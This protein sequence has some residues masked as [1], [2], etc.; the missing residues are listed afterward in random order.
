MIRAA[1]GVALGVAMSVTAF[2]VLVRI[3]TDRGIQR[4]GV[5]ALAISCAGVDDVAAWCHAQGEASVAIGQDNRRSLRRF[6][7]GDSS[8]GDGS[9][10]SSATTRP[11]IVM[12]WAAGD[13]DA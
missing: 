8:I 12:A 13:G 6:C 10:V 4:T 2:P 7:E 11:V 5:G 1:R 9:P 3:L